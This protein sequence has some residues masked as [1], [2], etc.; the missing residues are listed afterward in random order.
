MAASGMLRNAL[1]DDGELSL[2]LSL[3][4]SLSA[5]ESFESFITDLY[6]YLYQETTI[7][8]PLPYHSFLFFAFLRLP[9]TPFWSLIL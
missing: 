8:D 9:T 2:S 3:P 6:R 4:L 7:T 1:D 5:S